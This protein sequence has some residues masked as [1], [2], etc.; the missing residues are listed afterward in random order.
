MESQN[1]FHR[2]RVAEYMRAMLNALLSLGVGM[3]AF[4]PVFL[5]A[6]TCKCN[7]DSVSFESLSPTATYSVGQAFAE[8]GTVVSM[9][10][11]VWS[12]GTPT[13]AGQASVDTDEYSGGVGQD[14]H[15][16]NITLSF[17]FTCPLEGLTFL[18]GE[19]GG[20]LN[21]TINGDFRNFGNFNE[22]HGV[23]VGGV[24]VSVVNGGGNDTG[25]ATLTGTVN[26]FSV[27]GQEL[28]VDNIIPHTCCI[29]FESL[30][31]GTSYSVG[32]TFID[33]G[34]IMTVQSFT[35]SNGTS[36]SGGHATVFSTGIAGAAGLDMNLNNVSLSFDFGEKLQG[37]SLSFGEYG[38]NLNIT[39]NGDFVNFSDFQDIHNQT[40]GRTQVY[41]INGTGQDKGKLFVFGAVTSFSL[42][43]QELWIDHICPES[44]CVDFESMMLGTEYN[45]GD[46]FTD[47]GADLSV[48]S[49]TWANG[50]PTSSGYARIDP[51]LL[52]GGTGQGVWLN[53][54]NLGIDFGCKV[55]GLTL[56]FG[57]YGGNL[58][59]AINGDFRNF[60]NFADINGLN[61]GDVIVEVTGGS[62]NDTGTITLTGVIRSFAV[63]GQ[64]LII[65]TVCPGEA[66]TANVPIIQLL[67]LDE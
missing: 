49:F 3:L 40:I 44:G 30:T 55:K 52:A 60:S 23:T 14:M 4:M 1:D 67:I 43:G 12:N 13:S 8:G 22:L 54:V 15:A 48:L 42:G 18:F 33:S 59:I 10:P 51:A 64:E 61:I 25:K 32:S 66:V 29:D 35:W 56:L 24:T 31:S 2:S 17:D 11:F 62:G 9:E 50:N 5:L 6:D 19:Y 63:G 20:N 36:Y 7:P 21:I 38:G 27:G 57:E 26:S 45:V 39:I 16:N 34:A 28:W 53:N 58:N 46:T 47:S 41:A 65:D 37:L